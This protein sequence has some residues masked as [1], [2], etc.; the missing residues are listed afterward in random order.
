MKKLKIYWFDSVEKTLKIKQKLYNENKKLNV[1]DYLR[2]LSREVKKVI[3]G[4]DTNKYKPVDL[5]SFLTG[6]HG[7]KVNHLMQSVGFGK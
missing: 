4:K 7:I 5:R 1:S 3:S 2:K 6:E